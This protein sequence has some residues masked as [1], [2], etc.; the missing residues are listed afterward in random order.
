MSVFSPDMRV[1]LVWGTVCRAIVTLGRCS[2]SVNG[3]VIVS[4]SCGSVKCYEWLFRAVNCYRAS[5]RCPNDYFLIPT[6][7]VLRVWL[8]ATSLPRFGAAWIRSSTLIIIRPRIITHHTPLKTVY[9]STINFSS[10][11]Y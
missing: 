9:P 3:I 7:A 10:L 2:V 8:V 11:H 5:A 1:G 6:G 4:F